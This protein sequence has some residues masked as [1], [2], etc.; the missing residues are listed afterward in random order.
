MFEIS[1]DLKLTEDLN[2]SHACT[3]HA[4]ANSLLI[5]VADNSDDIQGDNS[6]DVVGSRAVLDVW[7]FC[8]KLH[9]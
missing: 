7:K 9:D 4:T 1:E 6:L 8:M 2:L 5:M 3:F